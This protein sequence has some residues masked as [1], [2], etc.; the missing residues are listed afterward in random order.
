MRTLS[1]L[2]FAVRSC[3]KRIVSPSSSAAQL[4][5]Y[6]ILRNR[7]MGRGNSWDTHHGTYKKGEAND[8]PSN[9]SQVE[10]DPSSDSQIA[11]LLTH[12]HPPLTYPWIP[13]SPSSPPTQS[14]RWHLNLPPPSTPMD[15]ETAPPAASL[16]RGRSSSTSITYPSSLASVFCTF[17]SCTL[18]YYPCSITIFTCIYQFVLLVFHHSPS[19]ADI[20]IHTL[21]KDLAANH[22]F[23]GLQSL[24]ISIICFTHVGNIPHL[25]L[26]IIPMYHTYIAL[27]YHYDGRVQKQNTCHCHVS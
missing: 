5:T 6:S 10:S 7:P 8:I 26:D 24:F 4:K 12:T 13:F 21:F 9:S 18:A 16:L 15:R 2:P 19:H 27:T 23:I 11:Y 3:V 17:S 22:R 1:Q 20:M 14:P 25:Y